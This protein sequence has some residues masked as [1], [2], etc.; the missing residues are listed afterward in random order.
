[1]K[2]S[3]K[4]CFK[5]PKIHKNRKLRKISEKKNKNIVIKSRCHRES[6]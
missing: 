5:K 2:K 4:N 6:C 3:R 1:M